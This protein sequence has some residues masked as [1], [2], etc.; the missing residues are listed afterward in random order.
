MACMA[1]LLA[2]FVKIPP[3]T[4]RHRSS[5]L[6]SPLKEADSA[7]ATTDRFYET[8]AKAYV[9]LTIDLDTGPILDRFLQRLP[10]S[11]RILDAGCGSGRDV[12]A[13]VQRGCVVLGIDASGALAALAQDFSGARCEVVRLEDLAY[14]GDFDGVWACASLFHLPREA[15]VPVLARLRRA[16][17]IG[18]TLFAALQEGQGE[19]CIDDGRLY[20]FYSKSEVHAALE[21]AGFAVDDVWESGDSDVRGDQPTWINVFATAV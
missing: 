2:N 12:R 5:P 13:F 4:T 11:P 6:H 14:E 1:A 17:V 16:L 10:P 7:C 20:V 3:M 8:H 15:F 21:S 18:G 9:A 19:T